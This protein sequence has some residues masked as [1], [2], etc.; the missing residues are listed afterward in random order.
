MK[1]QAESSYDPLGSMTDTFIYDENTNS[2]RRVKFQ[3]I[4]SLEGAPVK[5]SKLWE[6]ERKSL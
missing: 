1:Y 2:I 4:T 6:I 5:F 3:G